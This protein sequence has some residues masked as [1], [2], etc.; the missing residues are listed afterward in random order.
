MSEELPDTA[1]LRPGSR[2]G[3]FILT[4]RIGAGGSGTVWQATG[5]EGVVALKLVDPSG[6]DHDEVQRFHREVRHVTG[7][8][9]PHIVRLHEAGEAQGLL[10]MAMDFI[11]G[12][13]LETWLQ[14]HQ[15]RPGPERFALAER[16]LRKIGG[17]LHYIHARGWIHRDVK[18]ANILLGSD[19]RPHLADFGVMKSA[20]ATSQVTLAGRL[21]GTIAFMP[22][23]LIAGEALDGR[24]DLYGLGAVVYTLLALKRPVEADSIT[25]YLAKHL[26]DVPQPPH[27]FDPDVPAHLERI[28][29]RLLRKEPS[30]RYETAAAM[31]RALD[32]PLTEE[33]APLRGRDDVLEAWQGRLD[34]LQQDV[35]GWL[36]IDG[37]ER[38]GRSLVLEH[39]ALAA[40]E[41]SIPVLR[42]SATG[43]SDPP[44]P[45]PSHLVLLADDVD[46]PDAAQALDT[47]IDTLGR[48]HVLVA[49]TSAQPIRRLRLT[50]GVGERVSLRPLPHPAVTQLLRDRN[51]P[52]S[53]AK[54][55]AERLTRGA[56]VQ[57]GDAV[58]QLQALFDAG[59]LE[60]DDVALRATR[61]ISA[62]ATQSL[63]TPESV[64]K[65]I[66]SQLVQLDPDAVELLQLLAV[67]LRPA[68]AA[69]LARASS[70][71]ARIP[72]LLDQL[73]ASGLVVA[74]PGDDDHILRL[75]HPAS[76]TIIRATLDDAHK[77]KLH[78]ALA[79]ALL[80]FGR[81]GPG[82]AEAAR[83]LLAA[84]DTASAVPLLLRQ[85][86]HAL[87]QR[88]YD[89]A[90]QAARQ[91]TEALRT[92]PGDLESLRD[93]L[94][95]MAT[96]LL[97]THRWTEA[98]PA[99]EQASEVAR[100]LGDAA[101]IAQTDAERGRLLYRLGRLADAEPLLTAATA[102][103]ALSPEE[104]A[105]SVRTLGDLH[106][107]RGQHEH[108]NTCFERALSLAQPSNAEADMARAHRGLAHVAAVRGQLA[109]AI[110]HFAAAD[111]LL[112]DHRDPRVRA[113]V[114]MRAVEVDLL[115]G[116]WTFA[117]HRADQLLDL[118]R[119]RRLDLLM[120]DAYALVSEVRRRLNQRDDATRFSAK[121]IVHL[122]QPLPW[123]TRVRV[124]RLALDLGT[125]P[126][127]LNLGLDGMHATP[128]QLHQPDVQIA[129]LQTRIL[130]LRRP[131]RVKDQARDLALG[132]LPEWPGARFATLTD[133]ASAAHALQDDNLLGL[134]MERVDHVLPRGEYPGAWAEMALRHQGSNS[135]DAAVEALRAHL[136]DRVIAAIRRRRFA[137]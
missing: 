92:T 26:T 130:A 68:G 95:Y 129:A 35:S 46:E 1:R 60:Q 121:A 133:L 83:H 115:A 80:T 31:L 74:E 17:A 50:S 114:L 137:G 128:T 118:T 61:P 11:D 106:L 120:I 47:L 86:R 94:S 58:D 107:Q 124:L 20:D 113:G 45:A 44:R 13:D 15:R 28:C 52:G 85:A 12:P 2:F 75:S 88:A 78:K 25:G 29:L 81:R 42:V 87:R 119:A 70:R 73:V 32:S 79:E 38:S 10:W 101:L 97:A 110:R 59:W 89:A 108:A 4:R 21:V 82:A 57:P 63:P 27:V 69:V 51:V 111:E 48:S 72:M 103:P 3:R 41:R 135:T 100:Q 105:A 99:L 96:A 54:A 19:G 132:P 36:A 77:I 7:V 90:E 9:H 55:L 33:L 49:T 37:P 6:L 40:E 71:P 18:P 127:D 104:A 5:D 134:V 62:F 116:R 131:D 34:L 117:L 65:R 67:M 8:E 56:A 98:V 126:D 76:S 93:A 123:E 109:N 43:A 125:D 91:A 64:Q 112:L 84:G 53:I 14:D 66:S 39:L 22:P 24:A 122:E 136:P 16:V 30:R 23:E 102:S